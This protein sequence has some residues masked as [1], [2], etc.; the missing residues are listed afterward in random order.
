MRNTTRF[1]PFSPKVKGILHGADYNPDQW[2]DR[3]DILAQDLALMHKAGMN[4]M[5]VGIF[6]WAAL[7]PQEGEYRFEWLDQ[8]L[9]RLHENGVFVLL[10][11][12]SA[13]RPV[14]MSRKYPEVLS[15]NERLERRHHGGRQ[16][17]CPTSPV[18]REKV[19]QINTRLASRYKDHPA[20][21]GW[22]VSNEYE[23]GGCF[24]PLCQQ[25]FRGWLKNRY[26]N[27]LD[28]LNHAWWTSFWSHTYTAWSQIEAPSRL[29]ETEV[30]G[31][32][33]DWKRFISDQN[34]D[35]MK[36]EIGTL[37]K[38]CPD[39]PVTTNF[40]DFV[41]LSHGLNY[42][43]FAKELDV[44][45]WDNYPYWHNDYRSEAEEAARRAF[46]HDMNRSFK[47]GQPFLLME[48][49]PSATNWQPVAKL[50]KPGMQNLASI[51]A[52]AHGADS[53]QYFQWRKSL[54]SSEKFHGA[55]VDHN[56]DD[57][58]HVAD[59][60]VFR[61]VAAMG[62]QLKALARVA[63]TSVRPE[64]A[65][66]Y[67]WENAWILNDTQGPRQEG[68]EYFE[69][70][71]RHYQAFWQQGIPVDVLNEEALVT[72]SLSQYKLIIAPMMYMVKDGVGEA[73]EAYVNAGGH[74]VTTYW[75]GIADENDLCFTTGRPGPL[76]KLLGIW[77]EE[78]DVLYDSQS[79]LVRTSRG[80]AFTAHMFCDL[81]HLEGAEA[82]AFY[83][84]DF[85]AG[86]PAITVNRF[87]RGEAW[88]IAFR[89]YDGL[90]EDFY[91][92]MAERYGIEKA[93]DARL[94]EGVSAAIRED[95]EHR[96]VFLMNFTG[97]KQ[98]IRL[99]K[100]TELPTYGY[101]ILDILLKE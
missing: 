70:C 77:S 97:K 43:D 71:V 29:G 45:S 76:R 50:L 60:R 72:R 2:L 1:A 86:R 64:V 88:Y 40:H 9:D 68:M 63:G 69:T 80:L 90:V 16:N 59:T 39:L 35:F 46:I 24:C 93:I 54:G 58:Q 81:I 19:R 42:W 31:L 32:N 78:I 92:D 96:F 23:G 17:H 10:A 20:V 56:G 37:R 26:D 89:S 84:E 51:Q 14:W 100:T 79:N 61:E 98:E 36:Q 38:I 21:I 82:K 4:V 62:E 13:A 99:E 41:D 74:F 15:M 48:S 95:A 44:I 22:H 5:S 28:K 25:A 55:V 73:L 91:R 49:S 8:I 12:P 75:S 52:V 33:L 11:T 34:L 66:V 53:V 3:P 85:Y 101:R 27:D 87:G 6:S 30:H 47:N 57:P 67:D 7:E 83:T 18:Y 94:P 65:I